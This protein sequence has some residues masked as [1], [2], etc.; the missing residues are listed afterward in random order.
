MKIIPLKQINYLSKIKRV[1][2][3]KLSKCVQELVIEYIRKYKEEKT[4]FPPIKVKY[5]FKLKAFCIIDGHHRFIASKIIGK[6]DINA[7]V[8]Y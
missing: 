5:N 7:I 3:T 1:K 4:D 2:I 8:I 6:K